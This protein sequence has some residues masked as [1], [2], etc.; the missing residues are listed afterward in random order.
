MNTIG[1]FAFIA[2]V[3]VLFRVIADGLNDE[4]GIHVA[5]WTTYQRCPIETKPLLIM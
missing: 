3:P 5:T 2:A 4:Q 1:M